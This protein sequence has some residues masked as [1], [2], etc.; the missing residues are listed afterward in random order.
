MLAKEA[1]E[2]QRI[3]DEKAEAALQRSKNDVLD[4]LKGG[5]ELE[6]E[7][8]AFAL[9]HGLYEVLIL[10]QNAAKLLEEQKQLEEEALRNKMILERGEE[11]GEG[12]QEEDEEFKYD[13]DMMIEGEEEGGGGEGGGGGVAGVEKRIMRIG[14]NGRPKVHR[15]GRRMAGEGRWV[16]RPP[17]S[18][19]PPETVTKVDK[20]TQ[21]F[22][23]K[24]KPLKQRR[25]KSKSRKRSSRATSRS[26][27]PVAGEMPGLPEVGGGRTEGKEG[28]REEAM[29]P[30]QKMLKAQS[31]ERKSSRRA[32]RSNSRRPS[33]T[34]ERRA[35]RGELEIP[36]ELLEEEGGGGGGKEKIW[37][38]TVWRQ[39]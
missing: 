6:E 23:R 33:L 30:A 3:A 37:G 11:R 9:K 8:Q 34:W 14:S 18:S 17:P 12:G 25:K 1:A 13:P 5:K 16:D 24:G 32:S 26:Q 7:Q 36:V 29:T 31:E 2:L 4:M 19:T 28:G 39:F 35:S 20:P 21:I 10:G 27:S 22:D 15:N 38:P